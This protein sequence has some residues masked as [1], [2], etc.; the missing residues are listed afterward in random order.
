MKYIRF[1]IDESDPQEQRAKRD[2]DGKLIYVCPKCDKRTTD[3]VEVYHGMCHKLL[4][5]KKQNEL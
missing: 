4:D 3:V 5:N 1:E 2:K